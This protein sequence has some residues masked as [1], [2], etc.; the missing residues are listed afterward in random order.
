M[1]SWLCRVTIQPSYL[2]SEASL[3]LKVWKSYVVA[4]VPIEVYMELGGVSELIHRQAARAQLLVLVRRGHRHANDLAV[5]RSFQPV[6]NQFS[7]H[8]SAVCQKTS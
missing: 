3:C 2:R 1:L 7:P 6:R 8:V 4:G 5:V